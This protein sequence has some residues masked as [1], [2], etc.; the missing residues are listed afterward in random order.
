MRPAHAVTTAT[1]L[2]ATFAAGIGPAVA[3]PPNRFGPFDIDQD[4]LDGVAERIDNDCGVEV[5]D[6]SG[7][8]TIRYTHFYADADTDPL[9][10]QGWFHLTI[11]VTTS[12]GASTTIRERS[13]DKY[14]GA[15]LVYDS[16]SGRATVELGIVGHLDADGSLSG[17]TYDVC[18]ALE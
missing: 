10:G 9:R 5:A 18:T 11:N 4:F 16:T 8:G 17:R 14:A 2:L 6:I 13:M 3:V 12:T 1:V 15:D 7:T